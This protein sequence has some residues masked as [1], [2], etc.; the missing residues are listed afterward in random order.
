MP[1]E[2]KRLSKVVAAL[3]PCSRREAEQYIA[4]GWVRVDGNVVEEPQF[5]VAGERVEIDPRAN[6]QP[7]AP[8]T[9]LMHKPAGMSTAA[10]LASL[11]AATHWPQDASGIRPV[12]S[13]RAGLVPLLALPVQAEG[14]SV[15]SQDGRIVRKLREDAH[16]IEQE[17]LAEVAGAIVAG[18]LP[19]LR[20]GLV[21]E[22]R[23][24]PPAHVSWQSEARLRFAV[25]AIPPEMLPWMCAQVGLTLTA[26]KRI[27]IGRVPM[28]G[29]PPGQWRYL[30]HGE[31]F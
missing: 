15:F 16:L 17:L 11:G 7:A 10:A 26:L 9:F 8:A 24:L 23:A 4:E 2:P 25:K 22:G 5:R 21:F 27:R 29:L 28:A 30:A 19:R 12:K 1:D 13:H 3:V 20:E 14:L 18:G 6:L 31:R